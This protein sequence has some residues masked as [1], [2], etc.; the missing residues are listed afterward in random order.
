M[1]LDDAWFIHR[2]GRLLE[3]VTHP[4][5]EPRHAHI[6]RGILNGSRLS[7]QVDVTTERAIGHLAP[8]HRGAVRAHMQLYCAALEVFGFLPSDAIV[9]AA[10]QIEWLWYITPFKDFYRDHLAHVMKVAV[11]ALDLLE[12]EE[13]PFVKAGESLLGQISRGL[14]SQE[15]G[16]PRLR[17][18]A[19]R[20]G[21]P[22]ADLKKAAFWSSAVLETTR[23]AGLLH[24]MAY[25]DVMAA[26]VE[27]AA[28]P[29]RAR[30]PF[31]PGLDDTCRNAVAML[32]HH[33]V[34]SPFHEGKLPGPDGIE[35]R[36]RRIA[37]SVFRESHSL[38]AGYGILR[39]LEDSRRVGV[40]TPFDAF[41]ME[42]AAL[43]ISLHDYD[44]FYEDKHTDENQKKW[45]GGKS[46]L[47]PVV[48]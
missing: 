3:P 42:W 14:A 30:A 25:P 41:V 24:D 36:E 16:A 1:R 39:I 32:Q 33:L 21:I 37:E 44:K 17:N 29:V 40:V 6:A 31:E 43:A 18:A 8:R 12:H 45:L 13:S 28:R 4:D 5:G 10:V 38:R 27:R 7:G 35:E 48:T 2:R 46:S 19:R 15:L 11:T 34:A 20:L 47:L 23:L 22:D 9:N 26:K